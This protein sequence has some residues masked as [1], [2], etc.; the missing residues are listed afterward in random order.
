MHSDCY[1]ALY[2][3]RVELM[4]SDQFASDKKLLE[5]YLTKAGLPKK[6]LIQ[7]PRAEEDM[8]VACASIIARFHFIEGIKS[9]SHN[10]GTDFP[11]GAGESV[12]FVAKDFANAFG[13][14]RLR[15]VAKTHFKTFD[16]LVQN[17]TEE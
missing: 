5:S 3:K 12:D 1:E 13:L 2:D 9:L 16:R 10:Y 7:A 4:I 15:L 11:K 14:S 8:A 6:D 17:G